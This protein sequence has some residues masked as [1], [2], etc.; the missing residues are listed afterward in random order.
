MDYVMKTSLSEECDRLR[1]IAL[2]ALEQVDWFHAVGAPCDLPS[3]WGVWERDVARGVAGFD[4]YFREKRFGVELSRHIHD[5]FPMPAAWRMNC[6]PL[7]DLL[8]VY[9]ELSEQ[10]VQKIASAGARFPWWTEWTER[11]VVFDA[12]FYAGTI[13]FENTPGLQA[14]EPLPDFFIQ[15]F[16]LYQSGLFLCGW[17]RKIDPRRKKWKQGRFVY[18]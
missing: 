15:A 12:K 8:D 16:R 17:S 6:D 11:A 13:A 14:R 7:K 18:I 2:P 4:M 1:A 9:D 10:I 5:Y 3:E